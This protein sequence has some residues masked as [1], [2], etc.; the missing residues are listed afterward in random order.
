MSF[1]RLREDNGM[2]CPHPNLVLFIQNNFH[3]H[4][5]KKKKLNR[6]G[7]VCEFPIPAL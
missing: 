3:P 4:P 7:W 5:I 2:G 1:V 6:I